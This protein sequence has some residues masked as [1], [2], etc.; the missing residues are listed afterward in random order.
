MM[1]FY[2][3]FTITALIVLEKLLPFPPRMLSN[4]LGV[5]LLGAAVL[6]W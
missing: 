3:M 1:S 5:V 6:Q 2:G 4:A